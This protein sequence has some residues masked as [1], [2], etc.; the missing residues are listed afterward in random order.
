[1]LTKPFKPLALAF[2]VN[3]IISVEDKIK[4]IKY[5]INR[6][7]Y[8]INIYTRIIATCEG[9]HFPQAAKV[10]QVRFLN[11]VLFISHYQLC[12]SIPCCKST[13]CLYVNFGLLQKQLINYVPFLCKHSVKHMSRSSSR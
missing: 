11:F 5:I 6:N 8:D 12:F 3:L 13:R 1:M 4:Y 7:I 9:K 10:F 2:L